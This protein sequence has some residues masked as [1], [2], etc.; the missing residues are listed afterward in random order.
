MNERLVTLRKTL[1]LTLKEFGESIGMS[2]TGLSEIEHG[3][4][5]FQERHIKLILA[6]F[7]Q[8]S[9]TWLRTG[10]GDMFIQPGSAEAAPQIPFE[11]MLE[12]M[13]KAYRSIDNDRREVVSQY[14]SQVLKEAMAGKPEKVFKSTPKSVTQDKNEL[15]HAIGEE[16]EAEETQAGKSHPSQNTDIPTA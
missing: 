15:L 2:L 8:V 16:L 6:A 14:F 12:G 3:R 10:E 7:P 4:R 5:P 11:E 9:E 1:G 13:L